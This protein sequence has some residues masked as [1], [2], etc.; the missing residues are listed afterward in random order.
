MGHAPRNKTFQGLPRMPW[1]NETCPC[2]KIK[3]WANQRQR[4]EFFVLVHR[5]KQDGSVVQ[6]CLL[7]AC[8]IGLDCPWNEQ[9]V[10][11]SGYHSKKYDRSLQSVSLEN[12]PQPILL[13]WPSLYF[14]DAVLKACWALPKLVYTKTADSVKRARW[15]ARQTPNILCYLPPSNSRENGVP[16]CGSDEWRNHPN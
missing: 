3:S 13:R 14:N 6:H 1:N 10:Y 16:I 8:P 4:P 11:M 2:H 9:S 15:L 5:E 7:V 12:Q